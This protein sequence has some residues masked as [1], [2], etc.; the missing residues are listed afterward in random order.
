MRDSNLSTEGYVSAFFDTG[1]ERQS[2]A[3]ER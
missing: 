3:S 2:E 1:T